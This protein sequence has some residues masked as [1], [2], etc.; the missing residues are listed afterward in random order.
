MATIV[1]PTTTAT[2]Y[3]EDGKLI[4]AGERLDGIELDTQGHHA[5]DQGYIQVLADKPATPPRV[6]P[7]SDDTAE[8]GT[9]SAKATA[10]RAGK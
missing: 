6:E 10:R 4:G 3:T 1:N 5:A 7:A 8:P 2:V 9:E